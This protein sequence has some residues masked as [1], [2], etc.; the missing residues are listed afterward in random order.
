MTLV[1]CIKVPQIVYIHVTHCLFSVSFLGKKNVAIINY[2]K[3]KF[4]SVY[5]DNE[6]DLNENDIVIVRSYE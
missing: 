4:A 1:A 3:E 2:Q 6:Y 5:V